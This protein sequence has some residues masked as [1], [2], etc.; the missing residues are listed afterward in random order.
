MR[1]VV[2]IGGGA[3]GLAA[4]ITAARGGA[5]VTVL[6]RLDRVGKKI[7]L[8]GSGRCN[9][10]NA[11]LSPEH[12]H[13]TVPTGRIL[14][15]FDGARYFRGLGVPVRTD[16]EGRMYPHSNTAASVLDAL[17]F[18]AASAGVEF[19]CGVQVTGIRPE[20]HG[21]TVLCG[22]EKFRADAVICAAGGS[23]APSC[24]TD[25]NLLPILQKL[26]HTVI[27][28]VPALCPI[29]TDPNRVRPMKGMRVRAGVTAITGERAVKTEIGEL[30]F[31][32]NTLSGICVFNLARIAALQKNVT[33]SV[34]LMPDFSSQEV[35]SMVELLLK[36]RGN[37]PAADLL[38]GILPKRTAETLLRGIYGNIN[39]DARDLIRDPAKLEHT[40]TDWRFP[41]TGTANFAQAQVTAGGIG[42][43]SVRK[44]LES[45][46][47][48]GL[49]FCGELLDADGDCGGYNL[50][51]AW[52]SGTEAAKSCLTYL[53]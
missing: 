34:N 48:P 42:G 43:Q 22:D 2:I 9:L 19:R 6:E 11:S 1:R 44:N 29:P 50:A 33:L 47:V 36:Q 25:G 17:R 4:A 3:S 21:F 27:K 46:T 13:G 39:A 7:L 35:H 8:T 10:C 24:G 23:A 28:P 14:S 37:L 26:G 30:Q 20:K 53:G 31:T 38:T 40:L 5:A 18:A 16:S 51:W 45:R 15:G 12:Y 49:F 32:E 41:V 52:A